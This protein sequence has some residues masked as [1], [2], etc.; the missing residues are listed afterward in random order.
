VCA[1]PL[2]LGKTVFVGSRDGV[3]YAIDLMSGKVIWRY[4]A[5]ARSPEDPFSGAPIVQPAASDGRHVFFGAENLYFYCL[6]AQTGA[7]KWRAKLRGQSFQYGWPVLA[8]DH[9]IVPVMTSAGIAEF[10]AEKELDALPKGSAAE[11]WPKEREMF[12]RWLKEN[13]HQQSMWVL[14]KANGKEPYVLPLGRVGGLN[15]PP[16]AAAL[17]SDGRPLIYWRTKTATVLTGGTFG[18][19]YTPDISAIDLATGDRAFFTPPRKSGAGAEID[20]NFTLTVGDD[21]V[22]MNNH[23][24]GAHMVNPKTGV[25]SRLTSIMADWDGANFRGWGNQV[26]YWGNDS[27][28]KEQLPPS[29]HRSPQGDSGVAIV[30]VEGKPTLI[31]SESGHYQ[32]DFG[33]IV[34][35]EGK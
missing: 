32:I 6:D 19:K 8:G 2:V 5:I 23:M 29:A 27:N 12:L 3:F 7:E 4:G 25:S 24:R 26:I 35:L 10:V 28:R 31:F 9:V 17:Y 18:T 14:D 22:Y 16:R 11:V 30:E 15:Y 33:A 21:W 20:N 1:A 13:P 34:A